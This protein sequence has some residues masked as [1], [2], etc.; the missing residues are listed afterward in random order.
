MKQLRVKKEPTVI[1]TSKNDLGVEKQFGVNELDK[2]KAY[3]IRKKRIPLK[4][5][6]GN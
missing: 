5:H 3:G 2:I 1:Y 6:G 4:V